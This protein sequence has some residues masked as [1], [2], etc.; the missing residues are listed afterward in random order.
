M[1]YTVD[2]SKHFK[3]WF[4]VHP[5]SFM[6]VSNQQ[7]LIQ[8]RKANRAIKIWVIYSSELLT[9]K[10]NIDLQQ[11]AEKNNVYLVDLPLKKDSLATEYTSTLE[12]EDRALY[13]IA[14]EE[15]L[16]I[17]NGGNPAFASDLIRFVFLSK[18]RNYSD[19][20]TQ[21]DLSHAIDTMAVEVKSPFLYPQS[22]SGCNNDVLLLPIPQTETEREEQNRLLKEIKIAL[23]EGCNAPCARFRDKFL[24]LSS[25]H[26]ATNDSMYKV[27]HTLNQSKR[28]L[29]IPQSEPC[30]KVRQLLLTGIFESASSY[31]SAFGIKAA[32]EEDAIKRLQEF[33]DHN[34]DSRSPLT[35]LRTLRTQCEITM[36]VCISGAMA[37]NDALTALKQEI[38][39]FAL[40]SSPVLAGVFK[41]SLDCLEQISTASDL[42]WTEEGRRK[43][44][45]AIQSANE[46]VLASSTNFGFFDS[47]QKDSPA[48]SWL[49]SYCPCQ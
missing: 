30:Y 43:Q 40:G 33:L 20:D 10:A 26:M 2:L 45:Q 6:P 25:M 27:L 48:Q 41:F 13:Q 38:A 49:E 46:Q 24:Q 39:S 5:E 35:Y 16:N 37:F 4:S 44:L 8:F 12:D 11:F 17:H 28:L 3:I 34:K 23:I 36:V 47:R 29:S 31:L 22:P 1:P 42:S 15:L 18:F 19:F 21:I 32:N 14:R 7:R 9:V